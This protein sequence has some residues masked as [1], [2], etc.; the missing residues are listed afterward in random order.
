M[1]QKAEICRGFLVFSAVAVLL[2]SSRALDAAEE[3]TPIGRTV[4]NF[5]LP[6]LHGQTHS[7]DEYQ[8]KLVVVAFLGV[9]CPLAKNYALRLRDLA[10]EFEP[11]GVA[12]VGI[13][14]N[15]QDSLTE[16]ATYARVHGVTFPVLKDNNNVIADRLG[17]ERTPEV[18]L[19]D[20]RE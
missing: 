1:I 8:G 18:F 3:R 14:S 6:D 5:S 4:E 16:I 13:D 19:L 20:L 17:A 7:L 10:A 9:D 12:F 2:A 11:K 15:V